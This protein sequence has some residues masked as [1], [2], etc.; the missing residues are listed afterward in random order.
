MRLARTDLQ[1][2]YQIFERA[3]L[4]DQRAYYKREIDRNRRAA[5]QVSRAR[6]FFAF[7][8]GAASL[9][10]AI[11]GG[12]TAI[13]GGTASCDVSQLAAIADANLPSKQADQISNKLEATVTEGNTLVCLLLDTVTP[14]L[15]V[16]A[17]GAPAIG[18]AFTTL[19][20]MYQWDR[21]ASVY[22]TAQKSLAIADALSPLDEEPDD[23]YLASLQAYSE[24]TLTV[25]RDETAQ[26]GQ[27]VKMPDALQEYINTA[28]EKA[29]RE[30][31]ENGGENAGG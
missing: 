3:L 10:A 17:V 21:L 20:D 23:V 15:M 22:E 24:G 1:A 25:M 4:Q 30:L 7:L 6:A 26:W 28:R 18:A 8:A 11:I 5:Q 12:L 14:V 9:L 31:E 13:Q 29:A 27:L 16:I 2:R 19:A